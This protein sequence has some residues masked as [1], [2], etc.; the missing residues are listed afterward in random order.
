MNTRGIVDI[1]GLLD[2]FSV[3]DFADIELYVSG[4]ERYHLLQLQ[5]RLQQLR[6]SKGRDVPRTV[7]AVE[8]LNDFNAEMEDYFNTVIQLAEVK[9]ADELLPSMI[10]RLCEAKISEEAGARLGEKAAKLLSVYSLNNDSVYRLATFAAALQYYGSNYA[11]AH[12]EHEVHRAEQAKKQAKLQAKLQ[13]Q[14]QQ[15]LK[16]QELLELLGGVAQ[17][18]VDDAEAEISILFS[19]LDIDKPGEYAEVSAKQ[20]FTERAK[21]FLIERQFLPEHPLGKI[22]ACLRE[23]LEMLAASA[24]SKVVTADNIIEQ[25]SSIAPSD[26]AEFGGDRLER[27]NQL[28]S[29]YQRYWE[30]VQHYFADTCIN[31]SRLVGDETVTYAEPG[32]QEQR[33]AEQLQCQ[34]VLGMCMQFKAFAEHQRELLLERAKRVAAC[35]AYEA[36]LVRRIM[37]EVKDNNIFITPPVVWEE[38]DRRMVLKS[39][40]E[41]DAV[42]DYPNEDIKRLKRSNPQFALN[43]R[44]YQAVQYIQ[45]P[46]QQQ[47]PV[48]EQLKESAS[49]AKEHKALILKGSDSA[50]MVFLKVMA[51]IGTAL[52]CIPTVGM[53]ALLFSRIWRNDNVGGEQFA[54]RLGVDHRPQRSG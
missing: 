38:I 27:L 11:A 4:S 54:A 45:A 41:T 39:V 19:E 16:V 2:Q 33:V 8:R 17:H 48:A 52:L 7:D 9:G 30:R 28:F 23:L 29:L 43:I 46:L 3:Q 36:E 13:A 53:A 21:N 22:I 24:G 10:G 5:R 32:E 6:Q 26:F 15:Q 18:E 37:N 44:K 34:A 25:L 35:A 50:G 47:I 20:R 1:L 51:S 49:R 42:I 31:E 14:Q 12:Q 40:S